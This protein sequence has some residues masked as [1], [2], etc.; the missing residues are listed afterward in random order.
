MILQ[1]ENSNTEPLPQ[2]LTTPQQSVGASKMDEPVVQE[3][4]ILLKR[5]S[6]LI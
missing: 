6:G 5:L 3:E 4:L 2:Q 1:Q